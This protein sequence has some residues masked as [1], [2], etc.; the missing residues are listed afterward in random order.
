MTNL[1]FVDACITGFLT[2]GAASVALLATGAATFIVAAGYR[3]G[4]AIGR[5]ARRIPA[6]PDNQPG[7]DPH[8]LWECRRIEAQPLAVRKEDTP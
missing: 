7:T 8:L 6:A 5:R 1:E 4:N 3:T 2:C